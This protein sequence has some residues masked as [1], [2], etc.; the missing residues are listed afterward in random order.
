M[1]RPG[2]LDTCGVPWGWFDTCG[3][4]QGWFDRDLLTYPEVVPPPPPPPPRPRRRP[5]VH[6]GGGNAVFVSPY[7][8]PDWLRPFFPQYQLFDEEEKEE[9]TE[10]SDFALIHVTEGAAVRAIASGVVESFVDDKGRSSLVLTDNDG[11][12]YWY[13]DLGSYAVKSGERVRPGQIIARTKSDVSV[14]VPTITTPSDPKMAAL[15]PHVETTTSEESLALVHELASSPSEPKPPKP[16]QV[17]FVEAPPAAAP[18]KPDPTPSP[19]RTYL[20]L[21]IQSPP[22]PEA[23]PEQPDRLT[24]SPI[25]RAVARLGFVAAILAALAWINSRRPP[26]P[27]RPKLPP[28][29]T[30]RRT[31]PPP[32]KRRPLQKYTKKRRRRW[33]RPIRLR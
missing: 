17:V 28:K 18:P 4:D 8:L 15:P 29:R 22:K 24:A 23:I 16:T 26:P 9:A 7:V 33:K 12:R 25:V 11:T 2:L 5:P 3:Q 14:S 31:T 32:P 13:A 10:E 21:P 6:A 27:P 30:K 19:T 1:A 20:L